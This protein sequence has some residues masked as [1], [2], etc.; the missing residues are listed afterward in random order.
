MAIA[1]KNNNIDEVISIRAELKGLD[2]KDDS[3][4]GAS[5]SGLNIRRATFGNA[6]HTID[7]TKA[8]QGQIV[9]GR[10]TGTQGIPDPAFGEQKTTVIEGTLGTQD[11]ILSF[12]ESAALQHLNFGNAGKDKP[13]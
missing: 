4:R 2:E 13:K 11:F 1:T 6:G 12:S 7:I 9:N 8:L 5:V 10:L 3:S